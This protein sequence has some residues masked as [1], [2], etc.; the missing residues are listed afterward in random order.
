MKIQI[1]NYARFNGL[2]GRISDICNLGHKCIV[3]VKVLINGYCV[4]HIIRNTDIEAIKVDKQASWIERPVKN[5]ATL[6]SITHN[7]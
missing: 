4:E 2:E 7:M 1:G 6:I 3:T 5:L